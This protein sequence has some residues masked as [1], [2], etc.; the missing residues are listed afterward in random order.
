MEGGQQQDEGLTARWPGHGSGGVG[1]GAGSENQECPTSAG[2]P[3]AFLLVKGLRHPVLARD[4]RPAPARPL[5]PKAPPAAHGAPAA[6]CLQAPERGRTELRRKRKARGRGKPRGVAVW[7]GRGD[8]GLRFQ[9]GWCPAADG[10]EGTVAGRRLPRA[11]TFGRRVSSSALSS[12]CGALPP[13]TAACGCP[14][15]L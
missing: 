7:A 4:G 13:V 5:P 12:S 8:T 1:L 2:C 14:G 11:P 10:H 15:P 6:A 3:L 9:E